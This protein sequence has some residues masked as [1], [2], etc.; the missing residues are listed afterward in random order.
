[1]SG[2]D[3]SGGKISHSSIYGNEYGINEF[4][5]IPDV[6]DPY[7]N[8]SSWKSMLKAVNYGT[9]AVR[10]VILGDFGDYRSVKS[11]KDR[12]VNKSFLA[13][14]IK[15][16][17]RRL[18]ELSTYFSD[19][20]YVFGN[21]ED[22]VERYIAENAPKLDG[23]IDLPDALGLRELDVNWVR[24]GESV[25]L[26]K[27]NITHDVGSAGRNAHRNASQ[28]YRASAILGHTHMMEYSVEG[29]VNDSPVVSAMLGWLGSDEAAKEYKHRAAQRAHW[30]QGF[31]LGYMN[32]QGLVWVVPVPIVNG[33]C[34]VNGRQ[35]GGRK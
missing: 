22:R 20:T 33:A 26:G 8:E 13:D 16:S 19:I 30:T 4:L 15:S 1:M 5:L 3:I 29:T 25:K 18:K 23:L 7:V 12:S 10:A 24:Y 2:K 21:H 9:S 14:E 32:R 31:G 34:I 35:F 17:R 28:I 11:H 6:H 27:I